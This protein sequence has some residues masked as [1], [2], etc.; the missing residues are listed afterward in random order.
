MSEN[1]GSGVVMECD[2]D[3]FVTKNKFVDLMECDE[4][5][6]DNLLKRKKNLTSTDEDVADSQFSTKKG[7]M[8]KQY[9]K[10]NTKQV[11][12]DV[13]VQE[14]SKAAVQVQEASK[15][16]VQGQEINKTT[17]DSPRRNSNVQGSNN[18]DMNVDQPIKYDSFSKQP[19]IVL[20][21]SVSPDKTNMKQLPMIAIAKKLN[22]INIKFNQIEYYSYNTWKVS[23]NSFHTAN[24]ALINKYLEKVGLI[25]FVPRYKVF[26][27][28][29]I[30]FIPLDIPLEELKQM[31]E[32]ENSK[33]RINNA[34]RF[35]YKDR[36]T[37]V[38]KESQ[39]VCLEIKG[40]HIPDH[41]VILKT[42]NH[43]TPYI[44]SVRICYKC[45]R[46]GHFGKACNREEK[47]LNCGEAHPISRESP[48]NKLAT[49]LNCGER[50][51]TLDKTC[52]IFLKEKEITRIMA[53]DN[54]PYLEAKRTLDGSLLSNY[55][56]TLRTIKNF[57]PL[58]QNNGVIDKDN[59]Q[60]NKDE[61]RNKDCKI[62]RKF[63]KK[64]MVTSAL[65]GAGSSSEAED[66]VGGRSWSKVVAADMSET[67]DKIKEL[68]LLILS[69]P[70]PEMLYDRIKNTIELHIK[71]L[72]NKELQKKKVIM[73][74]SDLLSYPLAL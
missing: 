73:L 63:N 36:I 34:F 49:C 44:N 7:K 24:E 39:S 25:A 67:E 52:P 17:I 64:G 47:C 72:D 54:I 45:G 35:K 55:K 68:V 60:L 59:S 14:I 50:H 69:V 27:R 43:V 21:R 12:K 62:P 18:S 41:I 22:S 40:E 30:K 26:R 37:G 19:F 71:N 2:L 11:E 66:R 15:E 53:F 10:K 42:I 31:I 29:I 16:A 23:F 3:N 61:H 20:I 38:L 5:D 46:F 70:N 56:K 6:K 48:C 65:A 74:W 51:H 13:Q 28:I 9:K 4:F 33:I 32:E 8:V 1:A 58:H 57:P